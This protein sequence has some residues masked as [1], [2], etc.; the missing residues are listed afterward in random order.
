MSQRQIVVDDP[1]PEEEIVFCALDEN[2][3]GNHCD[4]FFLAEDNKDKTFVY[5]TMFSPLGGCHVYCYAPS[6]ILGRKHWTLVTMGMSGTK[7]RVPPD[8][9]EPHLCDRA[10]VRSILSS[11]ILSPVSFS[12]YPPSFCSS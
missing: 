9:P 6:E 7:M 5:S 10:E 12:H 8:V 11:S 1:L 2:Y 4:Q 3:L